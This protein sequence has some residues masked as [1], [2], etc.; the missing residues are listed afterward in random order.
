MVAVTSIAGTERLS[1]SEEA[2]R[3]ESSL[4]FAI[5]DVKP[6]DDALARLSRLVNQYITVAVAA[7][8]PVLRAMR[9]HVLMCLTDAEHNEDLCTIA[10]RALDTFLSVH[11][12]GARA[13]T[14]AFFDKMVRETGWIR[15]ALFAGSTVAEAAFLAINHP[16]KSL[17]V[18]D[19]GPGRPGRALADRLAKQTQVPVRYA[20]LC[21]AHKAV[22]YVDVIIMGAE[23]VLSNGCA[24]VGGGGAFVAFAAQAAG[25][26]LVI[27]TQ[28]VKISEHAIVDWYAEGDVLRPREIQAIVTE[29]DTNSWRPTFIPDAFKKIRAPSFSTS[30]LKSG[31]IAPAE[32]C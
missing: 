28:S 13:K 10:V 29:L 11:V 3:V 21:A 32:R 4:R 31:V 14:S 5:K 15:V 2:V 16:K 26:P 19:N 8:R 23:E 24:I 9:D 7:Q 25:V 12:I 6:T 1:S 27:T 30:G 20:P 17:T 18:I 22:E